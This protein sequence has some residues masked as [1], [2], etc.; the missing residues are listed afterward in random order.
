MRFVMMEHMLPRDEVLGFLHGLRDAMAAFVAGLERY[1]AIAPVDELHPYLALD[2]GLAVHRASLDWAER[3]IAELSRPADGQLPPGAFPVRAARSVIFSALGQLSGRE[4]PQHI[5]LVAIRVGHDHPADLAL[6]DAH[7][8]GAERFQPGDLGG[9]I[10][11]P[12]V[13]MQPVLDY[14]ALGNSQ[15]EQVGGD[16]ILEASLR[17]LED[18]LIFRLGRAPPA[19]CRLPE[20]RDPRRIAAVDAQALDAYIHPATV[21]GRGR[22]VEWFS[23]RALTTRCAPKS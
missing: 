11:R 2:H 6:A 10:A 4:R 9:L 1:S 21:V 5:E 3:T 12:Q 15:E 19:Q 23:P 17:G 16:T 13:Q 14:L 20:R 7:P 8:A 18:H 22:L